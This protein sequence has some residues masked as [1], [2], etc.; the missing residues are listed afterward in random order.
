MDFSH[1]TPGLVEADRARCVSG[2]E[3]GRG[4]HMWMADRG[5]DG[6][7]PNLLWVPQRSPKQLCEKSQC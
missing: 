3:V 4:S 6:Q 5:A 7:G 1:K 2:R